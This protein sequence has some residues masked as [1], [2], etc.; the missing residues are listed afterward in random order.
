MPDFNIKDIEKLKL[1]I[2]LIE[3]TFIGCVILVILSLYYDWDAVTGISVVALIIIQIIKSRLSKQLKQKEYL[4]KIVEERTIELRVQRD[5]V[6]KESEQLS[7]TLAALAEA[8]DELVRKER[9][10]TVGQLSKGLVDRILNPLNYINN[11]ASLSVELANDLRKNIQ[12]G[13]TAMNKELYA[14]TTEILNMITSNLNKITEHG[15]NTVRIVKAMEEL[16][17]D[18]KLKMASA[19]INNL[20]KVNIDVITKLFAKEIEEKNIDIS[21][22]GLT[23]SLMIDMNIEQ[24]S[25][26]FLNVMKNSIYAI[27]KKAEKQTFEPKIIVKLEKEGS[28]II[29]SIQDN[30]IGIEDSIKDKVFEPF[31]TTKPTAEASGIGLYVSREVVL[32]HK[33]SIAVKSEKNKYTEFTI[34]VP[35]HQNIEPNE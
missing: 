19:D 4:A 16:L 6:L 25:K 30:G 12:N 10:A 15:V 21:F 17:K 5:Q 13:E 14:D 22:Q 34:T 31:F 32:S 3:K 24:M 11:F 35:I 7:K 26:M 20:C 18:Q 8:Q 9:L 1:K 33:G 29:I 2:Q 28:Q 23:L 27:L